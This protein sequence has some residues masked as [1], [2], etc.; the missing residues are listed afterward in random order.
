MCEIIILLMSCKIGKVAKIVAED[1]FLHTCLQ[2][3]EPPWFI[4]IFDNLYFT[5]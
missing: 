3:I 2:H 1:K 5:R 4:V